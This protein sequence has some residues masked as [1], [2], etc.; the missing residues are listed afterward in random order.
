MKVRGEFEAE[1]KSVPPVTVVSR[2]LGVPRSTVY[3][4]PHR[5]SAP[6]IDEVM[7]GRVKA[8]IERYSRYGYRRVRAVLRNRDDLVV[9]RK[10]I[11]RIMKI[12][13]WQVRRRPAGHRPR[14]KGRPSVVPHS[15]TLWATDFTHLWCGQDAW[16][17]LALVIDCA[18]RELIGWRLS[19][20]GKA[21]VA[22]AALEDALIRR[23]GLLRKAPKP[24]MIR[25]DNGLVFTS[26]RYRRTVKLYGLTQE[27][28]T[29]YT[30]EQNGLIERFIQSLKDECVWLHRFK[31]LEHAREMI[32]NWIE[33]YNTERPHQE[34]N[35]QPP[36]VWKS[37]YAMS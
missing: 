32:G 5:Q 24:L 27:F 37:Q 10:K 25:S 17:H 2:V 33:E 12:R 19:R 29:P 34:L 18:D 36:T 26:K 7:A 20:S 11:Q 8:V 6:R 3:Y 16:C 35:Y 13:G 30:P 15:N 23:F 21:T 14:A 1:G 31:S 9:N 4:H 28:I 22:E